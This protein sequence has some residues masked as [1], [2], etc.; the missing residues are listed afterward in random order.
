MRPLAMGG[1]PRVWRPSD[2]TGRAPAGAAATIVDARN[3]IR[4]AVA[5]VPLDRPSDDRSAPRGRRIDGH[6]G[7]ASAAV[8][9]DHDGDRPLASSRRSNTSRSPSEDRRSE[10][11]A[12]E[13]RMGAADVDQLAVVVA[14]GLVARDAR[15]GQRRRGSPQ[16]MSVRFS[17]H[18]LPIPRHL[19]AVVD[20]RESRA[21]S[22][23]A[24]RR[25][26]TASRSP[27]S[28]YSAV[29]SSWDDR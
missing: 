16:G 4:P 11:A 9:R 28:L 10:R 22:S 19:L 23:A 15:A 7:S 27:S 26:G 17:G 8:D 2:A 13:R 29:G 3:A 24:P 1:V 20:R 12:A 21:R 6:A 25:A 5:A 14:Q 18:S